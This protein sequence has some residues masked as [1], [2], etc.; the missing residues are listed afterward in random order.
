MTFNLFIT[1]MGGIRASNLILQI[2]KKSKY[3]PIKIHAADNLKNVQS[4]KFADSYS[5]LPKPKNKRYLKEI[6]KIVKN[7]SINLIIPGS[8][9]EAIKLSKEK[10]KIEKK[11][12]KIASVDY[13]ILKKF[14]N[15]LSTYKKLDELKIR[16]PKWKRANN[17]KELKLAVNFFF[18][19]GFE[20]VVKPVNSRGGRNVSIIRKDIKNII[21]KNFGREIHMPKKYFFSR[22]FR[23][24]SNLF[25]VIV[26]ERL[27]EPSYDFDLLS[28]QGRLLKIV[29][30]KRIGSQGIDGNIIEV[31]KKNFLEYAKKITKGF[32]LSWLYDCDIMLNKNSKPV[33]ME[34]N[35]RI[36]GSVSSSLEAGIPLIDDLISLAKN[37]IS[38]IKKLNLKKNITVI[39]YSSLSKV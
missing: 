16:S 29:V 25:P 24:Y 11:N 10:K 27:Y 18:K 28:W 8:D 31:P 5:V 15:K 35:P 26:M 7:K 36:S 20:A 22:F 12:T 23:K 32:N 14:E 21:S 34:L 3:R 38:R 1:S 2:K 17:F 39:P 13:K 19:L 30:R 9:E 37:K 33:L 6:I 4:K